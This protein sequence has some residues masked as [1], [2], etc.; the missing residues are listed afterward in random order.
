MSLLMEFFNDIEKSFLF[1]PVSWED[2]SF[3]SFFTF[4]EKFFNNQRDIAFVE[5]NFVNARFSFGD[6]FE[7]EMFRRFRHA[8]KTKMQAHIFSE[9]MTE[10]EGGDDGVN[11][12]VQ[13]PRLHQIFSDGFARCGSRTGI[14]EEFSHGRKKKE[15]FKGFAMHRGEALK[16]LHTSKK[17]AIPQRDSDVV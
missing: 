15:G 13:A 5:V 7:F 2:F 14:V 9:L 4:V 3:F 8:C 6:R 1:Y 17:N 12:N 11:R 16:T 10:K